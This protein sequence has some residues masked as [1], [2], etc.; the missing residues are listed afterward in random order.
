MGKKK[1]IEIVIQEAEIKLQESVN[2][3]YLPVDILQVMWKHLLSTYPLPDDSIANIQS[4]LRGNSK[5]AFNLALDQV[6]E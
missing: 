5:V 4:K 1:E 2:K 3:N 6:R